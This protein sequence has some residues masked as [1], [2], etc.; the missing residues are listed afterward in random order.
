MLYGR[1]KSMAEKAKT[2]QNLVVNVRKAK[3]DVLVGGPTSKW[4][5]PNHL[6]KALKKNERFKVMHVYKLEL[7][8]R[9]KNEPNFKNMLQSQLKGKVLGCFCE[10]NELCH[11]KILADLANAD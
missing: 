6:K 4:R 3:C 8:R 10:T 2:S 9:I 1:L 7:E 11:A 5:L